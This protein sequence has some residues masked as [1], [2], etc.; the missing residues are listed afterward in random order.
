MPLVDDLSF[1]LGD[2]GVIL[3][4]D[5]TGFPF[6]D[7]DEVR[8]LDSSPFR[9][10]QRDHEGDDGGYIDAEFEKGRD[11]VLGGMLYSL[12]GTFE[13]YVDSLKANWAP[14]TQSMPLYFKSPGVTERFLRV[15][16]LGV[17]YN[18]TALRRTGQAEIQF[19]AFAEDPRIYDSLAVTQSIN[20]GATIFTGFGF[21][22]GFN[23]G[24]GGISS[25]TDEVVVTNTGNRPS[26]PVFTING[27]VTN[28]RILN[29]TMNKEMQFN[30]ILATG[31][32]LVVDP[33]NKT[34]KLNGSVNRRNTLLAPTWFYLAQG[35]NSIR[36]RAESSDPAS[37]LSILFR[38][39]W[40]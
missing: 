2:N 9:E 32:T 25:V 23:F 20:L 19:L 4:T 21:P 17:R 29:D 39:A 8:G 37:S 27:P 40:R 12:S 11:I 6:V 30:I 26:P 34:V 28:P 14:S 38:P 36:Y 16:P 31:E 18:W 7:I 15:K 1:R 13:S 5:S 33:R 24:F 22:F 35:A 10:T 3:N